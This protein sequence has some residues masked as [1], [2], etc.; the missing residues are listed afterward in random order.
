MDIHYV[1]KDKTVYSVKR[2]FTKKDVL[3]FSE[4][5][6]LSSYKRLTSTIESKSD[7][8]KESMQ[9]SVVLSIVLI[10]SLTISYLVQFANYGGDIRTVI[11]QTFFYYILPCI[12][13]FYGIMNFSQKKEVGLNKIKA[14]LTKLKEDNLIA[15]RHSIDELEFYTSVMKR[16]RGFSDDITFY[17]ISDYVS[18][19]NHCKALAI[20]DKDKSRWSILEYVVENNSI[21]SY[22]IQDVTDES[23][24]VLDWS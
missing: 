13:L 17:E 4:S 6:G 1:N 11:F 9:I 8:V 12:V 23:S 2:L 20:L 18:G 10:L 5:G 22:K 7:E 21:T 3:D 19:Q 16:L 24:I 14:T 15:N